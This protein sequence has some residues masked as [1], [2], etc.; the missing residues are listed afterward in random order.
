MNRTSAFKLFLIGLLS[1]T[2]NVMAQAQ[3]KSDSMAKFGISIPDAYSI[4]TIN[5]SKI[6]FMT[7]QKSKSSNTRYILVENGRID[8][9]GKKRTGTYM[10]ND[11]FEIQSLFLAPDAGVW[12]PSK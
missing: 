2:T 11:V 5:S 9:I 6:G 8:S 3:A 10:G 7:Q 4:T 1:L 12:T